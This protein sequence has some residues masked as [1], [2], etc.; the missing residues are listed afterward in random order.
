MF[1]INICIPGPLSARAQPLS[2]CFGQAGTCEAA[3][4]RTEG[5]GSRERGHS[6]ICGT[7]C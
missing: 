2:P 4:T 7:K 5:K 1:L 3:A 6:I